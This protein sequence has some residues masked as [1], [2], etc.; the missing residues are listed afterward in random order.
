MLGR[1]APGAPD[2]AGLRPTSPV[3]TRAPEFQNLLLDLATVYAGADSH[4]LLTK[5]LVPVAFH[6]ASPE[7][8][9]RAY[10]TFISREPEAQTTSVSLKLGLLDYN[11]PYELFHDVKLV[12][13]IEIMR[14]GVGSAVYQEIDQFYRFC[15]ELL[16][17]EVA[18][19]GLRLFLAK[20]REDDE[21]LELFRDDFARITLH[22][23]ASN[24]EFVTFIHKYTEPA[25]PIY[26]SAYNSQPEPEAKTVVQPLF[27]GLVGKSVLDT[28]N[29]VVPEPW[30]L[31]K[32]VAQSAVLPTHS[33]IKSFNSVSCKIPLPSQASAQVL[34]GFFHPNWYTIE[35]PK[36][37]QYKQKT[38]KPPLNSTL[39]KNC[40]ANELRVHEKR[41]NIVS[42]GPVID[43]RNSVLSD[44]LKK[45]IWYTNIGREQAEGIGRQIPGGVGRGEEDT[46]AAEEPATTGAEEP[47]LEEASVDDMDVDTAKAQGPAATGEIKLENLV[48]Y[49]PEAEDSLEQLRKDRARILK[50]PHEMQKVISLTLL[51]L[52]KLRQERYLHSTSP[53]NPSVAE[54]IL[55]KKAVKL[56]ALL[57][58]SS[59]SDQKKL[60]IQLSKK[61]PVLLNEYQGVL[62]GPIPAKP[63]PANKSGR[64]MGIKGPHKKKGR[65]L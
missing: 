42:L 58:R 3:L 1:T 5:A 9:V 55:Y 17:L 28:R 20:E 29:T 43:L 22:R 37:L 34:D 11:T 33:T 51:K 35:A 2:P 62:P 32:A 30:L 10:E 24:G 48:R 25:V 40:D 7:D 26:H 44:D 60:Q 63:I 4:A 39:V 13:G 6:E 15:V 52:N 12:C 61:I 53:A 47:A 19:L 45:R 49:V 50:A 65:F 41:S 56:L 31:T 54:T 14:H 59:V 57:A 18:S 27:S 64:L 36:W 38:L 21:L 23:F 16:L 8:I 46:A